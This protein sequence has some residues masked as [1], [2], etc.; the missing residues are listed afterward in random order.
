MSPSNQGPTPEQLRRSDRLVGLP[1][2][3]ISNP[4]APGHRVVAELLDGSK[5][6]AEVAE[7]LW[8]R[9]LVIDAL[10]QPGAFQDHFATPAEIE[11]LIHAEKLF[12]VD[13]MD[14]LPIWLSMPRT[15]YGAWDHRPHVKWPRP[16]R[17]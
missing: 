4:Q 3:T 7:E 14:A 11:I 10:E 13:I 16:V 12:G 1:Y 6:R 5:L 2:V 9:A 17:N 8:N 15:T